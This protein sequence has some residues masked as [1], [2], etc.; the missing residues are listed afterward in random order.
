MA[1]E[2]KI[3]IYH[4]KDQKTHRFNLISRELHI[5]KI[6]E[7]KKKSEAIHWHGKKNVPITTGFKVWNN[8]NLETQRKL[9]DNLDFPCLWCLY[10]FVLFGMEGEMHS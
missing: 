3:L 2:G 1:V 9:S 7:E 10:F 5:S 8:K 4:S 6:I